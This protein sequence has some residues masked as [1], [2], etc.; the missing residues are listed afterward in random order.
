MNKYVI[1]SSISDASRN[2]IYEQIERVDLRLWL[3]QNSSKL[4]NN[5]Q[6]SNDF[7]KCSWKV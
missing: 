5:T 6:T 2:M 3:Q 7:D 4:K 1:S